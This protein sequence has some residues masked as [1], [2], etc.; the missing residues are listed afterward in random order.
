MLGGVAEGA[1]CCFSTSFPVLFSSARHIQL[2]YAEGLEM[3]QF[4]AIGLAGE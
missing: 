2:V 3:R 1:L 4:K